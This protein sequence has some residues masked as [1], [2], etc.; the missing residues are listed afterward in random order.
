LTSLQDIGKIV[1][2]DNSF[3]FTVE[4]ERERYQHAATYQ[5]S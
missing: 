1:V 4:E 5:G 3:S 2:H